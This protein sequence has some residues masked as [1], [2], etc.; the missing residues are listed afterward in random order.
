VHVMPVEF[1]LSILILVRR[2]HSA[3][4]CLAIQTKQLFSF[5]A[6][7]PA[8]EQ[9]EISREGPIMQ[10]TKRRLLLS[11]YKMFDLCVVVLSFGLATLLVGS[12][13]PALSLA[14][15]SR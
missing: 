4:S 8:A 11:V 1:K 5:G 9:L 12:E 13:S 10:E 3:V 7:Q 6:K 15:S 2:P 14:E